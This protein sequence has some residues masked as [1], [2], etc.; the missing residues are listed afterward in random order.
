MNKR[1]TINPLIDTSR[2]ESVHRSVL[3]S[4][5]TQFNNEVQSE[6]DESAT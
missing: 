5:F 1:K 6:T 4:L 2:M 3:V